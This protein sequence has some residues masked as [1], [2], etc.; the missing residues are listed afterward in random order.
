MICHAAAQALGRAATTLLVV[1]ADVRGVLAAAQ[2]LARLREHTAEIRAV[3]RGGVL[4]DDVVTSSLRLPCAGGLPDQPKL[5]AAL[6]RGDPP[7]LGGRSP[8]GR[9][10][11]SFLNALPGTGR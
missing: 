9:F 1:T 6:N 8:L 11:A 2:V 10:C 4:D 7:S 3:V 5:T